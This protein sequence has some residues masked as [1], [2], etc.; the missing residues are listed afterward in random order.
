MLARQMWFEEST[1]PDSLLTDDDFC[2]S[3][4]LTWTDAC[5][6]FTGEGMRVHTFISPND[7]VIIQTR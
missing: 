7:T 3:T 2:N 5:K 4:M 6:A 1:A